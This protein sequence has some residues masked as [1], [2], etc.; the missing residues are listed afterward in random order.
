MN[1]CAQIQPAPTQ[2]FQNAVILSRFPLYQEI[3]K[4]FLNR[5]EAGASVYCTDGFSDFDKYREADLI[6]IVNL[7]DEFSQ[8]PDKLRTKLSGKKVIVLSPCLTKQL[9]KHQVLQSTL[10][11]PLHIDVAFAYEYIQ[12]Y[13]RSSFPEVI[14]DQAHFDPKLQRLYLPNMVDLTDREDQ[15]MK[16]IK[17][18]LSNSEIAKRLSIHINTVKVHVAKIC[19]KSGV[20]NRTQAVNAYIQTRV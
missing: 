4:G 9:R 20:R 3:L 5:V 10:I 19:R 7:A 12:N 8:I 1:A 2:L 6:V 16:S 14:S 11:L 13:I 15:I 18:G 17:L